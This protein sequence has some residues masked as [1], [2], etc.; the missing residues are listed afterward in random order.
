MLVK[1]TV[2]P[3]TTPPL[4]SVTVPVRAPVPADW[5]L[6]DG[7]NRMALTAA[8]KNALRRADNTLDVIFF[9]LSFPLINVPGE[10]VGSPKV[11]GTILC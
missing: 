10:M 11:I 4:E 7:V 5:P 8:K 1:A 6:T 3:G 2:T 9:P